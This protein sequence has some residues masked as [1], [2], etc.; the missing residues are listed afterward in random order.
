[1]EDPAISGISGTRIC[2]VFTRDVARPL[3][4]RYGEQVSIAWHAWDAPH[5]LGL[6][7]PESLP[8]AGDDTAVEAHVPYR[9]WLEAAGGLTWLAQRAE[10]WD[11][12]EIPL[13]WDLEDSA[14]T[15]THMR[16]PAQELFYH[17]EPLI[18]RRAVSL[19]SIPGE[20]PLPVRKLSAREGRRRIDLAWE[21][22]VTRYRELHGFTYGDERHVYEIDAGRGVLFYLWGVPPGHRLPLRAYHAAT[23]WKNGVPMGYIE[24][25]SLFERLEAGFNLYY[26][27]REGETAWLYSRLLKVFHDMLG[28]RC[29]WLD[30]YQIGHENEEAIASGA[31]WFYRKLGFRSVDAAVRR[32]TSREEKRAAV[33]PAYRTTPQTLRR[34]AR[35]PMVYEFA[36]GTRGDWDS[37]ETRRIGLSVVRILETRFGGDLGKMARS[38][39]RA[40]GLSEETATTHWA[41]LLAAIPGIGRWTSNEKGALAALLAAKTGS[42]E[43]DHL[44][45]T[46]RHARLR[47]ELLRMG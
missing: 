2:G 47:S 29:I 44:R 34:L 24:A 40:A 1:M 10:R 14:A 25:L 23:I 13:Q 41:A 35:K 43:V 30:P 15:R 16:L 39:L 20:P 11:E 17:R 46:Q 36:G 4:R 42:E 27:F 7:L 18:P 19:D 38:G 33:E 21:T 28:A 45:Q 8:L 22:S 31:F 32:L 5:R 3:V 12:L 26:T 37:F 9:E 6:I